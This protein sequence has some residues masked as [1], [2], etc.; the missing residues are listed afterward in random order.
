MD[1]LQRFT[2]VDNYRLLIVGLKSFYN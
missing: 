1:F 2:L